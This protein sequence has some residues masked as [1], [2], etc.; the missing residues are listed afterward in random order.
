M[1]ALVRKSMAPWVALAGFLALTLAAAAL[2]R[3]SARMRG[4]ARF[5]RAQSDVQ[6]RILARL[7]TDAALLGGVAALLAAHPETSAGQFHSYVELLDLAV[8]QPGL[9]G[10]GFARRL[11]RAGSVP[12]V[13]GML[14][15]RV[16]GVRYLPH[17]VR[18]GRSA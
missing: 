15:S 12:G 13:G 10:E 2:L 3:S 9:Q 14:M 8:R 18:D 1:V 4:H 7:Q 6:D 11:R 5:A 16:A 17:A